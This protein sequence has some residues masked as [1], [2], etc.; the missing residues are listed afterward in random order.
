MQLEVSNAHQ[1]TND[2]DRY[3]YINHG[4]QGHDDALKWKMLRE[5]KKKKQIIFIKI[6]FSCKIPFVQPKNAARKTSSFF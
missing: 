3:I 1:Y 2:I 5:K 4:K 6:N